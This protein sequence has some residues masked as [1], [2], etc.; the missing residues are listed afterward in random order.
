MNDTK[1]KGIYCGYCFKLDEHI[2]N[3]INNLII[4]KNRCLIHKKDLMQYCV[5]CQ[6]NLCAFCAKDNIHSNP[7]DRHDIKSLF[8]YIPTNYE[9]EKLNQKIKKR[10]EKYKELIQMLDEWEI[11][12]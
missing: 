2:K 6:K 10:K 8:E 9:I 12:L 1:C 4:T 5:N 11:K 7:N 3:N